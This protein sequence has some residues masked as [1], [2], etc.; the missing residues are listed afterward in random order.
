MYTLIGSANGN[1]CRATYMFF[2]IWFA[3]FSVT[4]SLVLLYRD[5]IEDR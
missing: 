4:P 5:I 3:R 1:T 2:C